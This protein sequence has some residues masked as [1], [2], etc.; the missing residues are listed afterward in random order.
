MMSTILIVEDEQNMRN[1]MR[2]FLEQ[3]GFRILIASDGRTAIYTTRAEKPEIVLLDWM[4]PGMSGIEVFERFYQGDSSNGT[5]RQDRGS[6]SKGR[7]RRIRGIASAPADPM[8]NVR[9]ANL[10]IRG[11]AAA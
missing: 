6:Q 4:L 5:R 1:T 2:G 8:F 11:V 9:L 10:R 7:R 3:E